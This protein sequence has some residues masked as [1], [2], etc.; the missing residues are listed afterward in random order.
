MVL[1]ELLSW[2][3]LD[4]SA[5]ITLAVAIAVV[6]IA[7][8]ISLFFAKNKENMLEKFRPFTAMLVVSFVSTLILLFSTP[9][10]TRG[11]IVSYLFLPL[12][13]LIMLIISHTMLKSQ[14]GY[15]KIDVVNVLSLVSIS[16]SF[17][18]VLIFSLFRSYEHTSWINFGLALVVWAGCHVYLSRSNV[19]SKKV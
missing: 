17:G 8:S 6:V 10:D 7:G 1:G 16:S 12:M 9:T 13:A 18:T 3:S 5:F 11:G 15:L 19:R 4:L 2:I 14:K